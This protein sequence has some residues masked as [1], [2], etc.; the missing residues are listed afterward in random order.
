MYLEPTIQRNRRRRSSPLRIAI[1]IALIILGLDIYAHIEQGNHDDRTF[2]PAPTPTRSA[3]SYLYEADT[4]YMQGEITRTIAAYEQALQLEPNTVQALIPMAHLITLENHPLK[5]I[6]IALQATQLAP[7]NAQ[8]WGA[9]CRAY[10]WE[11]NISAAIE[12]CQRAIELDPNYAEGYAYLAEA[13]ADVG[14]WDDAN[15]TIQTALQLDA[16]SVDVQRNYGYILELQGNYSGALTAYQNALAI[17][18][19]LAYIHIAVGK[20]HRALGNYQAAVESFEQAIRLDPH[21]AEAHYELGWTYMIYL[22]EYKQAQTYLEQA[23]SLDPQLGRAFGAL[24]IT[25]WSRRNYE[26]AIPSFERAIRLEYAAA[27]Q[28]AR[29]FYVTIERAD[30]DTPGPS[31]DVVL[32]GELSPPSPDEEET[33]VAMLV[34]EPLMEL[35]GAAWQ[36]VSGSLIMDTVSGQYTIVVSKLPRLKYGESY[37]GWFDGLR[38]L[39]GQPFSTGPLPLNADRTISVT[40]EATPVSGP[41]I[42][43]YYTLGLAYFY[44][45]ECD[46]AYPLFDAAL[47]IN[48]EESNALEGIRLC[49]QFEE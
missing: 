2:V 48:P 9:L 1:L 19:N 18:P 42:E 43:Y 22:G 8:A 13:Y 5:A 28:R 35:E 39:S 4:L 37:V 15:Q 3:I 44:L 38:T 6:Q 34:P 21:S 29:A 41:A 7:E 45:G 10:D 24:A 27:R 46:K 49:Q 20:N 12:A 17:N 23:T 26:A 31:V 40:L 33:L 11:G 25:Y 36:T 30:D 47:Q 32:R 14:R 16:D